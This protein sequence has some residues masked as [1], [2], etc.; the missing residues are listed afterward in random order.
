MKHVQYDAELHAVAFIYILLHDRAGTLASLL[1]EG[2]IKESLVIRRNPMT[3]E[4]ACALLS[5]HTLLEF[6]LFAQIM[7]SDEAGRQF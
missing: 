1:Y 6:K 2:A 4:L 3:F 5:H 7:V